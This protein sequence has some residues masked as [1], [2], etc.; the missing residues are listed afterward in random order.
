MK[1]RIHIR[2]GLDIPV[3]GEPEQLIYPGRKPRHVGLAI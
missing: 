3:G 1:R 2:K